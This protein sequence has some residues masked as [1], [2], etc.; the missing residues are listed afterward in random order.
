MKQA[1]IF[2]ISVASFALTAPSA[3]AGRMSYEQR[4]DQLER[5]NQVNVELLNKVSELQDEVARLRGILDE[6]QHELGMINK[7]QESLFGDLDQRLDNISQNTGT[8]KKKLKEAVENNTKISSASVVDDIT[9]YNMAYDLVSNRKFE[10]AQIALSDFIWRYPNSELVANAHYWIGEIHLQ[11][12]R[13]NKSDTL[14][15]TKAKDS[16]NYVGS[17]YKEHHKSAD[18]MVKLGMI[19]QEEGDTDRAKQIYKSIINV[20]KY[21]SSSNIAKLQLEKMKK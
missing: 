7:R 5:A 10:E 12:W 11:N 13:S 9:A 6:Q 14:S 16:F 4:L 20:A 17:N 15:L 19:A 2:F 18:S 21:S 3:F 1:T 8:E